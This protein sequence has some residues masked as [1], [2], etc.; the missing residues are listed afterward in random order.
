MQ[1]PPATLAVLRVDGKRHGPL[2]SV[3]KPGLTTHAGRLAMDAATVTAVVVTH[4]RCELLRRCLEALGAQTRTVD[5]ILVVDNASTDGTGRMLASEFSSARV[6]TLPAN[7]GGS[8][9][10]HVGMQEAFVDGADWLWLMDD[11]CRP[12]PSALAELLAAPERLDDEAPALLASRVE[13][14]DGEAHRTNIPLFAR[15]DPHAVITAVRKGLLPLRATTFV[16][17]LVAREAVE[18]AGLPARHYFYQGDDIEYTARVLRHASGYFVP[19]SVVEHLTASQPSRAPQ[20]TAVPSDHR[21][22]H[23]VRNGVYMLRGDAWTAIEKPGLARAVARDTLAYL[24][25]TRFRR[26]TLRV[27]GGALRDGVRD[28]LA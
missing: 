21:F 16:S 23:Q 26:T 13:W 6:V 19:E 17:L 11:D 5:R 1:P 8:G 12:R 27:L 25:W 9:G 14:R 20:P 2:P 4:D 7:E 10:F 15:S 18:H 24:R 3:R 28:P 22:R